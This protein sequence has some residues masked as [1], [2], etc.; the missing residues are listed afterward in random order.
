[1]H[2]FQEN[3]FRFPIPEDNN[4]KLITQNKECHRRLSLPEHVKATKLIFRPSTRNSA[5]FRPFLE[6][7]TIQYPPLNDKG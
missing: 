2:S 5:L 7:A 3:A 1:M 4:A 6:N